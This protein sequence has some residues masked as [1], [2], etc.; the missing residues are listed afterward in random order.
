MTDFE[1]ARTMMVDRQVRPADVTR[2]ALIDAMLW[3][4]RER[5]APKAKRAVAYADAILD[6]PEGRY[7]LSPMVFAKLLEAADVKPTDHVLDVGSA[8]G[9]SAGVLSRVVR[10]VVAVE[11]SETL[12]DQAE[13]ALGDV[14]VG[15]V[16]ALVR[17]LTEGAPE[18]GPYDVIVIEGGIAAAP[19]ALYDQLSEGGRLVA[20]WMDGVSG[21]ARVA[22]K[23]GGEITVRRA[24]DASAPVLA[25]FEKAPEF[26]F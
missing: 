3:A 12:S 20:I 6:L 25:G 2:Y 7:I 18:H 4:P 16:A 22:V 15:N 10:S 24:F 21:Q 5:F 9:Y 26:A 17:P 14:G 8:S 11:A 23:S 13:K 1:T 19:A